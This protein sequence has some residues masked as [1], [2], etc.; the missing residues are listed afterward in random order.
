MI[1]IHSICLNQDMKMCSPVP[2]WVTG[3]HHIEMSCVERLWTLLLHLFDFC[4]PTG[5]MGLGY[6]QMTTTKGKR[7]RQSRGRERERDGTLFKA[8][9]LSC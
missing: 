9:L 6:V 4:T 5:D 1:Q 8:V 3:A 2:V 7:T